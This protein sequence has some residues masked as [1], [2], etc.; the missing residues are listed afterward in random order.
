MTRKLACAAAAALLVA[1]G[2]AAA[3]TAPLAGDL[4]RGYHAD[5]TPQDRYRTSI[6]QAGAAL[7][8]ALDECRARLRP[9]DHPSCEREARVQHR[10]DM[11]RARTR[12]FH[13]FA[14]LP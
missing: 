9:E 4:P 11:A 8:E 10:N 6:K 12:L 14:A 13:E 7:R 3:E 5:P 1:C 2:G